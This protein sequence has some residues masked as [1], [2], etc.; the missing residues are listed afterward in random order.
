MYKQGTESSD[1]SLI[2]DFFPTPRAILEIS[3]NLKRIF[4]R[5][6]GYGYWGK[7]TQKALEC[8]TC[9][10][11]IQ[12]FSGEGSQTPLQKTIQFTVPLPFRVHLP[13]SLA[14]HTFQT[15]LPKSILAPDNVQ[16]FVLLRLLTSLCETIIADQ[17]KT[18]WLDN[19]KGKPKLD[20]LACIKSEY[21]D[22]PY[23][24]MNISR[25]ERSLLSQLRYR[26]LQIQLET[27]RYQNENRANRLCKICNSVIDIPH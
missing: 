16:I 9:G 6:W 18:R 17:E 10:P 4:F 7:M 24:K 2:S 14:L 1:L 20:F 19:M 27:R 21:G 22:E 3:V 13:S 11:R 23:I 25:Y 12:K 26:I 5:G 8:T 15:F